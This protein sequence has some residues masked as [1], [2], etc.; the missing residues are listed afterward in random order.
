MKEQFEKFN[1]KHFQV[2]PRTERTWALK[3]HLYHKG[4]EREEMSGDEQYWDSGELLS[5]EPN[6]VACVKSVS[7]QLAP[8]L[9]LHNNLKSQ[10][11]MKR[12]RD[13]LLETPAETRKNS[14]P[15]HTQVRLGV[16]IWRKLCLPA[17]A[18]WWKSKCK[19]LLSP[20]NVA[21]HTQF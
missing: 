6:H 7:C 16:R 19:L 9:S 8:G 1:S 12:K 17:T 14:L 10:V 20:V 4:L 21:T 15:L 3:P 18:A 5:W 13:R 2:C 11:H